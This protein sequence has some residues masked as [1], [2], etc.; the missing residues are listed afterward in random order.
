MTTV[1][2]S[3]VGTTGRQYHVGVEL[4]EVSDVV[5][6]PGEPFRVQ[7]IA[8]EGFAVHTGIN[9]TDDAF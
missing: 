2:K 6:M 7:L 4:G 9:A 3:T 1:G 5:L 8:S